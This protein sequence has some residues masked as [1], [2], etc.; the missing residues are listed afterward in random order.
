MDMAGYTRLMRDDEL[1][2]LRLLQSHRTLASRLIGQY[3]GRIVNTAGD[4]LLASFP[5]AGQALN[6]ALDLQERIAEVNAEVREERRAWFRIGL[7]VGEVTIRDGDVFGDCVNVAAR[8][9]SLAQNGTICL[10]G[11]AYE[12]LRP[13]ASMEFEDLGVRAFKNVDTPI[14]VYLVRP[15]NAGEHALP[16]PHRDQEIYLA[17]RF[18]NLLFDAIREA[19]REVGLEFMAAPVLASAE[20]EPGI[21]EREIAGWLGITTAKARAIVAKLVDHGLIEHRNE[22]S[23][24]AGLYLTEL[25]SEA[26]ARLRPLA[27]A[28]QDAVMTPLSEAERDELRRLLGRVIKASDASR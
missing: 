14:R 27:A 18:F 6:C 11:I 1:A 25:G 8:L 2:T 20:D 28:A 5:S 7:N 19:E 13:S 17:R 12:I 10:S 16:R 24:P 23:G 15:R 22:G 4:S 21:G 26:R 3:G 9:Q